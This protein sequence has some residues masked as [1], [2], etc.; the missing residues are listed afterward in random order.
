MGCC[1]LEKYSRAERVAIAAHK[2]EL[3]SLNQGE[4]TE[5]EVIDHWNANC[6]QKWLEERHVRMLALQREEILRYKWIESEKCQKDVGAQ[7]VFDWISRY[8]AGWRQWF[9][10]NVF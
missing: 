9:E 4:I 2:K 5:K 7:A 1:S 3:E 10:E 6:R 8:A